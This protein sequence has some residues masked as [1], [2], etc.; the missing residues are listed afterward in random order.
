MSAEAG[1]RC[2]LGFDVGARRTGVAVG[3][4][5]SQS[6]RALAVLEHPDDRPDWSRIDALCQSWRPHILVVGEPLTLDGEEQL[7]THRARRFAA[8]LRERYALP[9]ILVDERSTS[10]EANRR[11]ADARARGAA[12]RRDAGL[13]DAI[14]AQI[15][16]ERWLQA[17]MPGPPP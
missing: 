16:L 9:V 17:G 8:G 6:A 1:P 11:F 4:S 12:R 15:I 10:K 14:A 7:A 5:L 2:A 3:N 13:H